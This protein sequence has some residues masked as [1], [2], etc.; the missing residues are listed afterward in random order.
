MKNKS[1]F[2]LIEILVVIAIIGMLSSFGVAATRNA[3]RKANDTK[4]IA[5]IKQVEKALELFYADHQRYPNNI[6][7]GVSGSGEVLGD[8]QGPV[9]TALAPY[10]SPVPVDPLWDGTADEVDDYFF[11]Y[12]PSRFDCDGV[13]L[14]INSFET[15]AA[16]SQYG[17]QDLADG[18]DMFMNIAHYSRC[19]KP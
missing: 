1:G 10:M 8:N 12:D 9:E 4:R 3:R 7:E 14:S 5:S 16:V 15:Q 2:T 19:L 17:R 18:T 11:A 13:G 6:D